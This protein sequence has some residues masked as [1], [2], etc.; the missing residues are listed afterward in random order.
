MLDN[1][2]HIH[3]IGIG[4]SGIS[5]LAYL[6]MFHGLK[7]SGSDIAPNPTT[8]NLKKSG[9]RIYIGHNKQNPGELCEL[10]VYSEAIDKKKNPE[11][12]EAS[13]RGI[14]ALSYFEALGRISEHKKTIVVAGTHGKTTTT[15]MLGLAL[16][17]AK[18]DP[19]VVVGSQVA[20]F[21]SRNLRTGHSEWLVAEGC[22]YRRSFL[23][24]HP[25]GVVLLN[26]ELEHVD[27]Y[28]DEEDYV[29]AYKELV[30]KIPEDG[31]LVYNEN[32]KNCQTVSNDCKGEK[33]SVPFPVSKVSEKLK[34]KVAGEFN[35]LNANMALIAA[36]RVT[37]RT[38]LIRQGLEKFSGT[39]RR[40]EVKG[41]LNGVLVVDDYGHHPTEIRVTLKALRQTYDDRRLICVFQPHQY[42]RTYELLDQFA[43]AFADADMV[44]IPNIFEARDTDEDKARISAEKLVQAISENH[45]DCRWGENFEKTLQILTNEAKKGDLI[46]TMG[47]GDVYKIGENYLATI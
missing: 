19:T 28:K 5:A 35:E 40:M 36:M 12:M 47:A 32:D 26:C 2:R 41:E 33:I 46:V 43:H 23:H 29:A 22:E 38:D 21:E 25:F 34:L 27:Y 18:A 4:G 31:F 17:E 6:A 20:A 37:M 45:P 1:F 13:R 7:V 15:A 24:L 11:Y 16:I 10:V 14:P 30:A 8:E 9:A 44:I 42:S 3:F 39:A